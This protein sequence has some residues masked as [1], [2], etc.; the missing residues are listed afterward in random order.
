MR[1]TLAGM[2][3]IIAILARV[4]VTYLQRRQRGRRPRQA[5]ACTPVT[6]C[7]NNLKVRKYLWNAVD[8]YLILPVYPERKRLLQYR[9]LGHNYK[10]LSVEMRPRW[11]ETITG[12]P[13]TCT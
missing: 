12:S 7:I 2:S 8:I 3:A 4:T 11:R 10:A 5:W 13:R 9:N 6:W 1:K